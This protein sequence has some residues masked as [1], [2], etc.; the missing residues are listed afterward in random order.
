MVHACNPSTRKTEQEDCEFKAGL[1]YI[2][3]SNKTLSQITR[4]KKEGGEEDRRRRKG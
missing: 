4:K 2:L 3:S 1:V